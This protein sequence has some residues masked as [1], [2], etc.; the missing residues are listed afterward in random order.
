MVGHIKIQTTG[1]RY[2]C[3]KY[4]IRDRKVLFNE[5]S[6]SLSNVVSITDAK[7]DTVLYQHPTRQVKPRQRTKVFHVGNLKFTNKPAIPTRAGADTSLP[8]EDEPTKPMK[9]KRAKK[10][11]EVI[12]I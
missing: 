7:T 3:F 8:T 1:K 12:E 9:V 4:T 11:L 5:R 2:N 10:A 6:V